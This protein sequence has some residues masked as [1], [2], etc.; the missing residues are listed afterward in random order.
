MSKAIFP[1]LKV[2]SCPECKQVFDR[3]LEAYFRSG[4]DPHAP[5]LLLQC[6]G[7]GYKKMMEVDALPLPVDHANAVFGGVIQL[8]AASFINNKSIKIQEVI[9]EEK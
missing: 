2:K 4:T 5:Y 8:L 1:K 3:P 7:C 6:P 9:E